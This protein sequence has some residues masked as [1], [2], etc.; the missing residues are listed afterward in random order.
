MQNNEEFASPRGRRWPVVVAIVAVVVV[1]IG[2]IGAFIYANNHTK[3]LNRCHASV[4]AFSEQ[5]RQLLDTVDQSPKLQQLVQQVLG[6]DEVLDAAAKAADAAEDT[7][8]EQGCA[9]NATITQLNLVAD[10]LDSATDSL[11]SSLATMKKQTA[12]TTPEALLDWLGLSVDPEKDTPSTSGSDQTQDSDAGNGNSSNTGN[13]DRP[14]NNDNENQVDSDKRQL[15][16]SIAQG[17]A[18]LERLRT[19]YRNSAAAQRLSDGLQTAVD[20]AE[21][22]IDQSGVK[23]SRLYKAAKVTLDE[24]IQAVN[25]WIDEQA[26]KAQ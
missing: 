5:R 17:R 11:R 13:S 6:V 19:S 25:N 8:G 22:L 24:I 10:T 23:N 16:D 21:R 3:A 14:Q 12:D 1:V 18:L 2:G 26:A 20:T 15:S 9:A 4:A 7:V